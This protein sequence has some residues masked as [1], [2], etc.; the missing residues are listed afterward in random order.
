[1]EC[2][3]PPSSLNGINDPFK[4]RGGGSH[5]KMKMEGKKDYLDQISE[6]PTTISEWGVTPLPLR[7]MGSMTHLREGGGSHPKMK[8]E[9]EERLL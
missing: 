4:E 9:C 6:S 8:I 2:D 7:L 5:P 3:P 1:M